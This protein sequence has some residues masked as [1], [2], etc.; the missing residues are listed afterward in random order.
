MSM[1]AIAVS[2]GLRAAAIAMPLASLIRWLS[3][4]AAARGTQGGP[5]TWGANTPSRPWASACCTIIA[6]AGAGNGVTTPQ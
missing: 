6:I 2:K 5:S 4:A 3:A 1:A